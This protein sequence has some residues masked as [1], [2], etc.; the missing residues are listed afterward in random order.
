LFFFRVSAVS[1]LAFH[2]SFIVLQGSGRSSQN[3][4][5]GVRN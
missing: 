5:V 1:F 4:R 3:I 2:N